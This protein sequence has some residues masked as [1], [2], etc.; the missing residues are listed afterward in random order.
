MPYGQGLGL[1]QVLWVLQ[2][3]H[4]GVLQDHEPVQIQLTCLTQIFPSEASLGM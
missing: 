1:L 2:Q 3:L 4:Q